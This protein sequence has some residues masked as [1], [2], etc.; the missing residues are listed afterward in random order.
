MYCA[1]CIQWHGV[2]RILHIAAQ[3]RIIASHIRDA[4]VTLVL[5]QSSEYFSRLTIKPVWQLS[6]CQLLPPGLHLFGVFQ[7]EES[8]HLMR[9]KRRCDCHHHRLHVVATLLWSCKT[10]Q[11]IL[12]HHKICSAFEALLSHS[13]LHSFAGRVLF[14]RM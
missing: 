7:L 6:L 1:V 14:F 9:I 2:P 11:A 4:V 5:S 3:I 10:F 12:G 13:S 8:V